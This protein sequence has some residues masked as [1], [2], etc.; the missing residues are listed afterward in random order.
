[1]GAA[2]R[3]RGTGEFFLPVTFDA[4]G[5]IAVE[6]GDTEIRALIRVLVEAGTPILIPAPVV[7]EVWRGGAGRQAR[8][9]RFLNA[10]VRSG[11]IQIIDVTFEAAKEV[12]MILARAPMSVADAAVCHS[13]LSARGPVVTSD[14]SDIQQVIPLDR[15]KVV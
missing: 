4:G 13:A 12:G 10:G 15:L 1:M 6:R 2:I 7:A 3:E 5:L 8:L 9:A 14:P 11:D